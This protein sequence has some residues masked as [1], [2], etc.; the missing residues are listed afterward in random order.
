MTLFHGYRW[1]TVVPETLS[2]TGEGWLQQLWKLRWK[3]FKKHPK[4]DADLASIFNKY[5]LMGD[6]RKWNKFFNHSW[7]VDLR[8]KML[9]FW[10]QKY[11]KRKRKE[12]IVYSLHTVHKEQLSKKKREIDRNKRMLVHFLELFST[13][14]TNFI[15]WSTRKN[16]KTLDLASKLPTWYQKCIS[17]SAVH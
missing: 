8:F 12:T 13:A 4:Q 5:L 2:F 11:T 15:D 3:A 9:T 7:N 10:E 16:D 17:Q 14:V 6:S 1:L